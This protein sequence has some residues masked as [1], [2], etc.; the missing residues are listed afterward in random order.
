MLQLNALDRDTL[1]RLHPSSVDDRSAI[2][3]LLLRVWHESVPLRRGVNRQVTPELARIEAVEAETVSLRLTG[4]ES[5]RR[6]QLWLN[7]SLDARPYFFAAHLLEYSE[8]RAVTRI[9]EV[10]YRTERRDRVRER[11]RTSDGRTALL[12]FEHSQSTPVRA[13]IAD[14]SPSGFGLEISATTNVRVGSS[15][16]LS[17]PGPNGQL[18]TVRGR[19]RHAGSPSAGSQ[20][21]KVGVSLL[22]VFGEQR[23]LIQPAEATQSWKK[24][25]RTWEA[26]AAGA[27]A[28]SDRLVHAVT[29]RTRATPEIEIRDFIS[30]GGEHV[31]AITNSFGLSDHANPPIVLIPPAWGRTKETL[32]PLA[33]TIVETFRRANEPIH[34]VRFDGIR[35]RGESYNDPACRV[36]GREHHR[37][38][39]SQATA[40]VRTVISGLRR[41]SRFVKSRMTLVTFSAASLDGRRAVA[42]DVDGDISSWISVVGS[43]DLQSMMR[44]LS[45]GVDFIRGLENGVSFG[46]QEMLGVEVDIDRA[47]LDAIAHR[48]AYLEDSCRDMEHIRIPVT[49]IHGRHDAWMD[50]E[51]SRMMLS[52]GDSSARRLVVVP[53]GHQLR[54]SREALEVFQ[55][56][57]QEVSR[58][59][60]GRELTPRVPNLAELDLRRREER[61]RLPK[62]QINQ[63]AFW[64]RYLLG[65]DGTVGMELMTYSTPYT[66]FMK[67]QISALD[68]GL[69][70][71][72]ADFGSGTGAFVSSLSADASQFS[73]VH[74]DYVREALGRSRLRL[75]ARPGG[76]KSSF[77]ACD[78][79]GNGADLAIP[80]ADETFD[81]ALASLF[82][83]YVADPVA[84]LREIGRTLKPGGRLVVSGLRRDADVSKLFLDASEEIAHGGGINHVPGTEGVDFQQASRDFLNDATRLLDF[85]E[86]GLFEFRDGSEMAELLESAGYRVDRVWTAFGDPPQAVVVSAIKV[87]SA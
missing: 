47:G 75:S 77:V 57:A 68:P 56:I 37:F 69:G 87:T 84:V 35:R 19:I 20:W 49:W 50:L 23:A 82:I 40:D 79:S 85:E 34:V 73:V 70:H 65:R 25:R 45:G 51:R 17:I 67:E 18:S 46:L 54:S 12:M 61:R 2:H 36:E 31:R 72:I 38:T 24:A 76:P 10:V 43:A 8:Q 3:A 14:T 63:R 59:A 1:D 30:A 55:L 22:G 21:K 28:Q 74:L 71:R 42:T 83:S 78:L 41:D 5:S 33:A 44:V 58:L 60:L 53:T 62:K 9:P 4:F 13:V 48:N 66:A 80:I 86:I 6:T 27:A 52:T 81:G 26:V 64:K 7:F 15:V 11:S 29:R 32:L 39:F 16:A